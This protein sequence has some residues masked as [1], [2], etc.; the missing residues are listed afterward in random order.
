MKDLNRRDW[1]AAY[2]LGTSRGCKALEFGPVESALSLVSWTAAADTCVTKLQQ[3]KL[4]LQQ[5]TERPWDLL[6]WRDEQLTF[7]VRQL[8]L[9]TAPFAVAAWESL[10]P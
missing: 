3:Y 8:N 6:L 1:K 2:A 4:V 9:G 7:F 5:L 10:R